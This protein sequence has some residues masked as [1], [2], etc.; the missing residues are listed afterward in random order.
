MLSPR[1]WSVKLTEIMDTETF[2]AQQLA[3]A[4]KYVGGRMGEKG[5]FNKM[6]EV[7]GTIGCDTPL[8]SEMAKQPCVYHSMNVTREYEET[9]WDTDSQSKQQV[10]KTRRTTA[11]VAGNSQRVSFWVEDAT[12]KVPVNPEGADIDGMQVVDRFEPGEP[13]IGNGLISLGDFSLNVG[14]LTIGPMAGS[15]TIG[16]RFR[17]SVLPL[18][19]QIYVLGEAG[20]RSGQLAIGRPR[21]KGH[22][23]LI[24]L[25]SEE[26]LIHSTGAAVR[27]LL[28]GAIASG[29]A[30]VGLV[31]A[32]LRPLH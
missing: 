2:T 15:R 14:G 28:V 26:E 11:S 19:R 18:G 3:E 29:V 13:S 10:Q 4:A 8:T 32:G 6:A 24:S 12:G 9:Y 17:E 7:R 21:E 1:A 22:K 20:D 5:S 16:D 30:G 25:K 27:W 23:F 31:A